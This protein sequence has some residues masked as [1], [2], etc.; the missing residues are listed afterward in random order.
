VRTFSWIDRLLHFAI[1]VC[2][3]LMAIFVFGNVVLRYFFNSGITWSEEVSRFLFIWLIFLGSILALKDNEHLG[4]D[5]LL[6]KLSG[7]AKKAV[8]VLNNLLLLA[9][10]ALV[11]DGSWKL[12]MT[13]MDQSAPATNMPYAYINIFGVVISV[14]MAIIVLGNLYRVVANKTSDDEL[15]MT[16]DSEEITQLDSSMEQSSKGGDKP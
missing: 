3:A 6:K 4:V 14:G 16:T 1:A 8:F 9:T 5:T 7:K 15:I 10:L 12:T 11:A 2:L 13:N